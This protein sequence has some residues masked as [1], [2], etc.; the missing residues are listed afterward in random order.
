M[1]I[2]IGIVSSCDFLDIVP[3]ERPTDSD[4]FEDRNAAYRYLYSCYSYIPS[5]KDLPGGIDLITANEL[6]STSEH[7]TFASFM[8]GNYTPSNTIISH[9]KTLYQGIRQCY[10]LLENLDKVPDLTEEERKD[11]IAQANF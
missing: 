9:W 8:K 10:M 1:L 6:V 11:Y 2:L 7:Q 4:A 5:P 3:D